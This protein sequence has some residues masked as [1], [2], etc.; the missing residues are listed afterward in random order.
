MITVPLAA[1]VLMLTAVAVFF[2]R[3]ARRRSSVHLL[4]ISAVVLVIAIA[5]AAWSGNLN[6]C[7]LDLATSGQHAVAKVHR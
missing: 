6:E 7:T 2:Q 5:R 1:A 3:G 4:A